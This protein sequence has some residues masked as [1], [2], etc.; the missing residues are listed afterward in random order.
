MRRAVFSAGPLP[1]NLHGEV[2]WALVSL[3][4]HRIRRPRA[5]V[6]TQLQAIY[7]ANHARLCGWLGCKLPSPVDG[8]DLVRDTFVWLPGKP[9]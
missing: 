3:A 9:P 2:S 4:R 5:Y 1:A 7:G 6:P 8:A